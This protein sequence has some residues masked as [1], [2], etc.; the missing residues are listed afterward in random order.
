MNRR[1]RTSLHLLCLLTVAVLSAQG[2]RQEPGKNIGTVSTQGDLILLTLDEGALGHANLFDLSRR[3]LRFTPD[4]SGYR[5]ENVALQWDPEFGA[6]ITDPQVTLKNFTFPFS[7]KIG[8]ASCRE[9]V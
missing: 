7:G 1:N 9:R 4:G 3:T 6:E 8:R 2:P 5:V